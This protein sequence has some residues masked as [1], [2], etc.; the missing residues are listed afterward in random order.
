MKNIFDRIFTGPLNDFVRTLGEFLPNLLSALTILILGLI[1]GKVLRVVTVK[2][3]RILSADSFFQRIGISRVFEK[4][5]LREPPSV[6]IAKVFFWLVVAV[7]F[8]IAL[9]T[10][11]VPAFDV[12]LQRFLLY[13]PN[14]FI[15]V[16]IITIGFLLGNFVETAVLIAS[17][18][19]GI[20]FSKLLSKGVKLIIVL[21]A[22]TMA[23][24]QLGIGHDTVIITFVLI[25]GG[26]ILALSLAFGL[27]ARDIAKNYMEEKLTGE[28]KED[29]NN[30]E[31]L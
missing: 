15:A 7:F 25:L 12:L 28:D 4:G 6:F 30:I 26:I 23:L 11:N 13:L 1:I 10:L 19:A 24:E 18:N 29:K 22:S 2:S 3:F 16:L 8:T 20:K 21:L 17:V 27:G 14:F 9:Y 31:H 5:G